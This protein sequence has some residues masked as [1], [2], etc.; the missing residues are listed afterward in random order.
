M[1]KVHNIGTRFVQV[2][3]FP[4]NWGYKCLVRGWTQEVEEPFRTA[5]P[6]I[7]RLPRYRALV[8]GKWTGTKTEVEALK[9]LGAREVTYDDFTEEAGWTPAADENREASS[10]GLYSRFNLM[11]G[12]VDVLDWQT[13]HELAEA[14]EQH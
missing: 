7:V 2:T 5:E 12:A 14:S 11:D 13:Y 6:F 10:K 9:V 8:F 1:P 4:Y 3:K